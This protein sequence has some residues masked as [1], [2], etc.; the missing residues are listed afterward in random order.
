MKSEKAKA[1]KHLS[2][3]VP[4]RRTVAMETSNP[5]SMTTK[6]S[7]NPLLLGNQGD[8]ASEKRKPLLMRRPRGSRRS[9]VSGHTLYTI[10]SCSE[11]ANS[12]TFREEDESLRT[13]ARDDFISK[14]TNFAT[15]VTD[16]KT[17]QLPAISAH[18]QNLLHNDKHTAAQTNYRSKT[19]YLPNIQMGSMARKNWINAEVKTFTM[20]HELASAKT[21]LKNSLPT[22]ES[23]SVLLQ[24]YT[25]YDIPSINGPSIM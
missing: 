16:V 14:P 12:Q 4:L 7:E 19:T 5:L 17:E 24:K 11:E 15:I 25:F 18:P 13:Y 21:D 23:K 9:D 22:P 6:P 10:T 1:A 8:E 3:E 2:K 20:W